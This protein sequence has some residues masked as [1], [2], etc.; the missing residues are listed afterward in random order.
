MPLDIKV[1]SL[2][3]YLDLSLS[4]EQ[5]VDARK[6]AFDLLRGNKTAKIVTYILTQLFKVSKAR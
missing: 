4:S 5:L 1:L 6:K 3:S 2:V